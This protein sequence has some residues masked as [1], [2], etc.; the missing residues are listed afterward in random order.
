MKAVAHVGQTDPLRRSVG[1]WIG[2]E[3]EGGHTRQLLADGTIVTNEEGSYSTP[4]LTLRQDHA[5]ALLSSL[6]THFEGGEH[7]TR[8]RKDYDAERARVDKF[9]AHLTK[10]K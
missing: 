10:E 7:T 4:T 1:V 9:I 3:Q 8:L 2:W 6:L 5:R